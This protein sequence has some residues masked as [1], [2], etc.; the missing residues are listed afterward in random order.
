MN[1]VRNE[2]HPKQTQ[3]DE[4]T[5]S[6]GGKRVPGSSTVTTSAAVNPP[7]EP[8]ESNIDD[9]SAL[10]VEYAIDPQLTKGDDSGNVSETDA[11]STVDSTG[12]T[13]DDSNTSTDLIGVVHPSTVDP[14]VPPGIIEASPPISNVGSTGQS[15]PSVPDN[16]T[17]ALAPPLAPPDGMMTPPPPPDHTIA[18]P[19][20]SEE[21]V[22]PPPPPDDCIASS[23]P[24]EMSIASPIPPDE[25]GAPLPGETIVSA[26]PPDHIG[27]SPPLSDGR[28]GGD[29]IAIIP[30]DHTAVATL[31]R[32][33]ALSVHP[34]VIA[35]AS[36]TEMEATFDM[37]GNAD[38]PPVSSS[39]MQMSDGN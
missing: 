16:V 30:M 38:A 8:P 17:D 37:H 18:P 7:D 11:T 21:P 26:H 39:D 29:P 23:P 2:L 34:P 9:I 5:R 31:E 12:G 3:A 36:E 24:P 6:T 14:A 35:T 27:P 22:A 4:S 10:Q 20:P 25:M 32:F 1:K 13:N 28:R 15:T 33:D 19:P